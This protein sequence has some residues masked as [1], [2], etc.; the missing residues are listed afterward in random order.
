MV[1]SYSCSK[2]TISRANYNICDEIRN[3]P[4][5]NWEGWTN[6][7]WGLGKCTF[8]LHTSIAYPNNFSFITGKLLFK[9]VSTVTLYSAILL[10]LITVGT[11]LTLAEGYRTLS[12]TDIT[13]ERKIMYIIF[14]SSFVPLVVAPL[15][16]CTEIWKRIKFIRSWG[17]FQVIC[18]VF[19]I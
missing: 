5:A 2:S 11:V 7:I 13:F 3:V 1:I 10:V 16:Y 14:Y 15:L 19:Y 8:Y 18:N 12:L 17:T 4:P 9:L 6:R